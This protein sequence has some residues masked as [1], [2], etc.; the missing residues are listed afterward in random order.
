MYPPVKLIKIFL[1]YF[2]LYILLTTPYSVHSLPSGRAPAKI[3]TGDQ[4]FSPAGKKKPVRRRVYRDVRQVAK[5]YRT[6]VEETVSAFVT[7]DKKS[8]STQEKDT[9][10]T[11]MKLYLKG[12]YRSGEKKPYVTWSA[13]RLEEP[14]FE[15]VKTK[16]CQKMERFLEETVDE[17]RM[18]TFFQRVRVVHNVAPSVLAITLSLLAD[19]SSPRLKGILNKAHELDEMIETRV[20]RIWGNFATTESMDGP[21]WVLATRSA[22]PLVKKIATQP[23]D[24]ADWKDFPT[25]RYTELANAIA[26]L[27]MTM[28]NEEKRA[29]EEERKLSL[30]RELLPQSLE[31]AKDLSLV[32]AQPLIG[33]LQTAIAEAEK[34]AKEMKKLKALRVQIY[35]NMQQIV[36]SHTAVMASYPFKRVCIAR[37]N[38]IFFRDYVRPFGIEGSVLDI[39]TEGCLTYCSKFPPDSVGGIRLRVP[40]TEKKMRAF[41]RMLLTVVEQVRIPLLHLWGVTGIGVS[42]LMTQLPK[43]V[44]FLNFTLRGDFTRAQCETFTKYAKSFTVVSVAVFVRE[45]S[46]EGEAIDPNQARDDFMRALSE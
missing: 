28:D 42:E 30:I 23:F 15:D 12:K 39:E 38:P 46:L 2:L 41:S 37:S 16:T 27:I 17:E 4:D 10:A 45:F 22:K 40:A 31:S 7:A 18:A 29:A 43:C 11:Y 35:K 21:Y 33:P 19:K 25:D 32:P 20:L 24:I 3:E 14:G 44:Q 9:I 26:A 5:A 1:N 6:Q 8:F 34:I 13:C 36:Q